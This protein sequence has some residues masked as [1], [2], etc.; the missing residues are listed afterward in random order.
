MADLK[1]YTLTI[2]T[3][4]QGGKTCVNPT[5]TASIYGGLAVPCP[6]ENGVIEVEI[7]PTA[8]VHCVDF[9][10]DCEDCE[11]CPPQ[12]I[13]RCL[14]DTSDECQEC[15]NCID[16][17]CV[18]YCPDTKFCS[19]GVCIDCLADT[20]CPCD[21]QCVNGKCQCPNDKP[22][23]DSNGCCH[24]CID[25]TKRDGFC[26]ICVGGA[27]VNII[28]PSSFPDPDTCECKEC[29]NSGQCP[30][31]QCCVDGKCK[32]CPGYYYD[33]GTSTCIPLPNCQRDSD[34][35]P[36][37]TCVNGTCQPIVCPTGYKSIGDICCAKECDCD[38]PNCPQG[39]S[40]YRTDDGCIC[41]GC[42]G[43]C[44]TSEDCDPACLCSDGNCVPNVCNNPCVTG[45]DCDP[46]CGCLDNKCVPC[47]GSCT[48]TPSSECE[49]KDGCRCNGGNC[50][51]EP[52]NKACIEADDC[53]S[54]CGCLDDRCIDCEQVS[55]V[56]NLDCPFG[57]YCDKG[58]STCKAN[59]C[60]DACSS[61]LD[62]GSGC[63][64]VDGHCYPCNSLECT[65]ECEEASGCKCVGSNCTKTTDCEDELAIVKLDASCE[66]K[67]TLDTKDC[68]ACPTIGLDV[69]VSMAAKYVNIV[70][71][72]RKGL[73]FS[74]TRLGSTGIL[75]EEPVSG[76]ARFTI[77]QNLQQVGFPT[78]TTTKTITLDFDYGG[79]DEN[80]F[81]QLSDCN[82]VVIG[83]TTYDV[84][85]LV[86]SVAGVTPFIYE[87]ECRSTLPNTVLGTL[88]CANGSLTRQMLSFTPQVKCKTPL[89]SWYKGTSSS[90]FTK[91]RE[92][93]AARV[94]SNS[95]QD[96]FDGTDGLEACKYYKLVSD[97]GCDLSTLYS[98][99]G[100]ELL[101]TKLVFCQ[102]DDITVDITPNTCN[103]D[104]CI[105][106]TTVCTAMQN[107]D[108]K[109]YLNGDLY[110][111]YT[112]TGGVLFAGDL[113]FTYTEPITEVRL[114]FPCDDCNTCR[115]TKT[116][117]LSENPCSCS[118]TEL[119]VN[120]TFIDCASGIT[121]VITDGTAP[122][123]VV[124]KRGSTIIQNF[125]TSSDPYNGIIL[126]P[127]SDGLY[128]V[129]VTDAYGCV[130]TDTATATSCCTLDVLTASYNCSTSKITI[131]YTGGTTP[132]TLSGS[133]GTGITGDGGGNNIFS[134]PILTNGT[135]YTLTF[136]D[137]EGCIDTILLPVNCCSNFVINSAILDGD[138]EN[139]SLSVTGGSSPY[140]YSV[141]GGAWTAFTYPAI[142]LAAPL[143][144]GSHT[145]SIKDSKNC[146]SS[147]TVDC[148]NCATYTNTA[149]VADYECT[150][151]CF[152][153]SSYTTSPGFTNP[154][155][156]SVRFTDF[157]DYVITLEGPVNLITPW[158]LCNGNTQRYKDG[159][160]VT[161]TFYDEDGCLISTHVK[162]FNKISFSESYDCVNDQLDITVV[163]PGASYDVY[164]DDNLQ[165]FP[166]VPIAL[167]SG[168][169]TVRVESDEC[170]EEH[171]VLVSCAPVCD[172]ST[173]NISLDLQGAG[174]C[175]AS[176]C[177][178]RLTNNHLYTVNFEV[179]KRPFSG[180]CTNLALGGYTFVESF[181]LTAGQTSVYKSINDNSCYK[182]KAIKA[183]DPTCT[184][185]LGFSCP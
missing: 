69:A 161:F 173:S 83:A 176:Q 22:Y 43:P 77:T 24:A 78:N 158:T 70:T 147:T 85:S 50:E 104:I 97:C 64:C 169:H 168:S 185:E 95:Y 9:I 121:Y 36:C 114:D 157:E 18:P 152:V 150:T 19:D 109:L 46:G 6:Y 112:S 92:L 177:C 84:V 33:A 79:T 49:Q 101:P 148:T 110:G 151:G 61:G 51:G 1:R 126:G 127:L 154:I 37:H 55:C 141:D 113:C 35:P 174:T 149:F 34:C 87:N 74:S 40:C 30:T 67:G 146:I 165:P 120:A 134:V 4:T 181:T 94:D 8:N 105:R 93:Y 115:I 86:I 100:N 130:K 62:C 5:V 28:C 155:A 48:G 47:E 80:Q 102:P 54:G 44:A 179:Y 129:T 159:S 17:W 3:I 82:Q 132:L 137:D 99:N 42:S 125:N 172:I 124:I 133:F 7:D 14:C 88:T 182:Y 139:I 68:C 111:T 180:V 183:S 10:I 20:D 117:T 39:D 143:S 131:T 123:N 25:G 153:V 23:Q 31:N 166:Y 167:T 58:V 21:Q 45:E 170:S 136:T 15:E 59:P 164:V 56:T 27:W 140:Q 89:F 103:Q 145:L 2:G 144:F 162:T 135:T 91:F 96:I 13:R 138:C 116:L 118:A 73:S 175:G 90:T 128:S 98:C 38:N 65:S 108:Y 75:N 63:G 122:Y 60:P 171:S 160:Q 11:K 66:L 178:Y 163:T 41:V 72:L 107:L 53:E 142:V 52:C 57:C 16:G 12:V 119:A 26:E 76:I 81:S 184:V 32:C 71:Y 156:Y 29:I 106:E